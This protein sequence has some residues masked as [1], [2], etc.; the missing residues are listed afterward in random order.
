MARVLVVDDDA[1]VRAAVGDALELAG[2]EVLGA[3]DGERAL[4]AL[5]RQRPDV[6]LLDLR[7]PRWSGREFME[8]L[9]RQ[10]AAAP[11]PI[12]VFTAGADPEG[13]AA[14]L[15][16]PYFL[17]KPFEL[18]ALLRLIVRATIESSG[19]AA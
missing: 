17:Q 18:E 2:H 10:H 11:S 9:R 1:D 19:R 6:I 4:E 16:T 15:G 7:M 3:E 12:I 14:A 13:A 5:G 8:A